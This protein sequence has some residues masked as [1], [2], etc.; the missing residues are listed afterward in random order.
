[1]TKAGR[2]AGR[3]TQAHRI[4]RL[5]TFLRG[6]HYGA[7]YAEM[8]T[9]FGVTERQVRRDLEVLEDAGHPLDRKL[10][11]DGR[12]K[13]CLVDTQARSVKLTQRERYGLLAV[14]SVFDVLAGTSFEEDVR[15]ICDKVAGSLP[16]EERREL[17]RLSGRFI[18]VPEGGAKDYAGKDEIL[19]A[20]LTGTIRRRR[21]RFTYRTQADEVHTG[22][23]EPYAMLL[24]KQGIYVIGMTVEDGAAKPGRRPHLYAAER[25]ADAEWLPGETFAVPESFRAERFFDGAFGIF[26]GEKP[27]HVVIEFER[28]AAAH[29]AAR[30]WHRTQKLTPRK[31]GGVRLELDA[32]NLTQVHSW[33]LG[34]GPCARVLEPPELVQRMT[35]EVAGLAALYA[36]GGQRRSGRRT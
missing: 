21:V 8:S 4:L 12:V 17:A 29:V 19:D 24:W 20:L 9:E 14:R 7:S 22:V 6:R 5:L 28:S 1:M 31:G 34:W 33:V 27:Q 16:D 25:F 26:L 2:K 35:E 32:S 13:V 18:F 10:A 15:S 11:G 23:L 36:R 3:Y 30:R